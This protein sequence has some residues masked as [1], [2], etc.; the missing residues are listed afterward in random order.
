MALKSI[1]DPRN[2]DP[3]K[4]RDQKRRSG[5]RMDAKRRAALIDA[6]NQLNS[7]C[8]GL[9]RMC[10]PEQFAQY[11]PDEAC[12]IVRALGIRGR[13]LSD[14]IAGTLDPSGGEYP[15][16]ELQRLLQHG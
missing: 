16:E 3:K 6:A 4:A 15:I 11:E 7:I 9:V 14:A 10:E 8:I 5:D 13:Q 1:P 2:D 12:E